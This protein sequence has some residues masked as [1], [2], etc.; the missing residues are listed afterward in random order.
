MLGREGVEV[1]EVEEAIKEEYYMCRL[2]Y[3][4]ITKEY[5]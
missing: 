3:Q 5:R 2:A 1:V 4:S